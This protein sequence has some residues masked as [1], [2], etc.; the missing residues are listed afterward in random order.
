MASTSRMPGKTCMVSHMCMLHVMQTAAPH[1]DPLKLLHDPGCSPV[2]CPTEVSTL[3]TGAER[4]A[5]GVRWRGEQRG[6]GVPRARDAP[7]AVPDTWAPDG[8]SVRPRCTHDRPH[9]WRCLDKDPALV[10]Q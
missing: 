3:L 8:S 1:A 10:L 4:D 5:A 9:A 7:G 6:R 2:R